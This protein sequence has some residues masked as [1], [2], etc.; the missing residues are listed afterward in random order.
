MSNV[1]AA[2]LQEQWARLVLE[3]LAKVRGGL[4]RLYARKPVVIVVDALDECDSERD[5]AALLWLLA[6][7]AAS[8]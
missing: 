4:R 5:T 6:F 3:P 7:I 1:R 2:A 8:Q